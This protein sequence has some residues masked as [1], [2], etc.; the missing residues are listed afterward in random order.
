MHFIED[1]VVS[2]NL[3]GQTELLKNLQQEY[4]VIDA[5]I[6]KASSYMIVYNSINCL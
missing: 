6:I 2:L 5:D 4:E 3:L 1:M